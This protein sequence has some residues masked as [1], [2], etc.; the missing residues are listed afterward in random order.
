MIRPTKT[1]V[2]RFVNAVNPFLY[3]ATGCRIFA[4][5]S[6]ITINLVENKRNYQDN[7]QIETFREKI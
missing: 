1:A 4:F 3:Q 2:F 7:L 6:K 5:F